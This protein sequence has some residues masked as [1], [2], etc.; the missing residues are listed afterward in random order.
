MSHI[1]QGNQV[2]ICNNQVFID[3]VEIKGLTGVSYNDAV[4]NVA[5]V[6]IAFYPSGIDIEYLPT[7]EDS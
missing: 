5:L 3:G 1:K 4:D 2:K 7:T 6:R